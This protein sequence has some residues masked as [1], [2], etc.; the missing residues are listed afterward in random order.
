M[1]DKGE[2]KINLDIENSLTEIRKILIDY[3]A[4]PF[5]F[6]DED[7]GNEVPKENELKIKLEDIL[8]GKTLYLKKEIIKNN[9]ESNKLTNKIK[10]LEIKLNDEIN[11]NKILNGQIEQFKTEL[12]NIKNKNKNLEDELRKEINNLTEMNKQL[13]FQLNNEKKNSLI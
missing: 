7:D 12:Y 2:I 9:E 4:F 5:L 3:F 6:L 11:K 1:E 10:E 8:D 13:D